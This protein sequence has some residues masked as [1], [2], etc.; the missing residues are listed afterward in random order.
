MHQSLFIIA[1]M[2]V[3]AH[4]ADDAEARQSAVIR[5]TIGKLKLE[6]ALIHSTADLT[7]VASLPDAKA[8]ALA[9]TAQNAVST[10]RGGLQYEKSAT[11]FP[12]KLTLYV[13]SDHSELKAFLR[14]VEQRR[15]GLEAHTL[16]LRGNVPHVAVSPEPGAKLSDADLARSAAVWSAAAVLN[17]KAGLDGEGDLPLWFQSG[18]GRA[19]WLRSEPASRQA[20]HRAKIRSLVG[21]KGKPTVWA[22]GIWE[23]EKLPERDL[24]TASLVEYLAFG[25]KSDK[26][27][28]FTKQLKANQV[29]DD[30][31]VESV[32]QTVYELNGESL[33]AAW[34]AWVLKGR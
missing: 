7:V 13:L 34:K 32:L 21:G 26:F 15:P 1:L 14:Q 2:T 25:P 19:C 31:S 23:G 22:K 12:G 8:K 24:V 9:D 4:A 28:A 10:A 11:V 5:D 18:F 17:A 27:V 20:T 3:P 29:N 6:K 33:D 30:P 16:S